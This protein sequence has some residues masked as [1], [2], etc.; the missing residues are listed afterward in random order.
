VVNE[1][2][3]EK[4]SYKIENGYYLI[5]VETFKEFTLVCKEEIVPVPRLDFAELA[6]ELEFF[7]A[8]VDAGVDKWE[9]YEAVRERMDW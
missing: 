3:G 4:M 1:L 5:P 2:K 8:L 7:R 6:R 9:G